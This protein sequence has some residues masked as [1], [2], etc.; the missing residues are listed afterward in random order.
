MRIHRDR[1]RRVWLA[2]MRARERDDW[3]ETLSDIE[4]N[5]V[6]AVASADAMELDDAAEAIAGFG[7]GGGNGVVA[8][9]ARTGTGAAR[10]AGDPHAGFTATNMRLLAGVKSPSLRAVGSM[11]TGRPVVG[12]GRTPDM[13]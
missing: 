13:A 2:L 10:L 9:G 6:R 1:P 4:E 3:P 7:M 8:S 5:A 11:P 12:P